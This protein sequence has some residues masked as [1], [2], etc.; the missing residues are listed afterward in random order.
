M[1]TPSRRPSRTFEPELGPDRPEHWI[2][3]YDAWWHA[4][5]AVAMLYPAVLDDLATFPYSAAD[6]LQPGAANEWLRKWAARHGF[7]STIVLKAAAFTLAAW[8]RTAEPAGQRR[9]TFPS[10]TWRS[11][12]TEL[13]PPRHPDP[14]AESFG[15]WSA[16]QIE[17]WD[18]RV[19]EMKAA[20]FSRRSRTD[21]DHF[22]WW[23][24]AAI[25]RET[26]EQIRNSVSRNRNTVQEAVHSVA[27]QLGVKP[28]PP[29]SRGGHPKKR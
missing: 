16:E 24:R 20:G 29:V 3:R 14:D 18:Q 10:Y 1:R 28:P 15:S 26:Y 2:G 11:P 17:R 25:G 13:P 4:L 8:G 19:A 5:S 21:P 9:W 12:D 27:T 22:V 7:T 6:L 23:A